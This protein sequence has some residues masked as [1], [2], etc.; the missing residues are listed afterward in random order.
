MSLYFNF[1]VVYCV[2]Y[3][4]IKI[5]KISSYL[6]FVHIIKYFSNMVTSKLTIYDT[7]RLNSSSKI[8]CI[9]QNDV[10]IKNFRE[11]IQIV[12]KKTED[13]EEISI[14]ENCNLKIYKSINTIT[15][16]K[17]LNNDIIVVNLTNP[18]IYELK[19]IHNLIFFYIPF[20]EYKSLQE[21]YKTIIVDVKT[22]MLYTF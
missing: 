1:L 11:N 6:P 9:S 17:I 3:S 12:T 19:H 4:F 13:F 15:I 7:T 20:E 18:T 5:K 14:E 21:K 10:F 8:F 22:C 2:Y 16:E